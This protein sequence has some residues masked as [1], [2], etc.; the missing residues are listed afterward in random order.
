MRN[1]LGTACTDIEIILNQQVKCEGKSFHIPL[2]SLSDLLIAATRYKPAFYNLIIRPRV[3]DA[4]RLRERVSP[5]GKRRSLGQRRGID[6]PSRVE[7]S[8]RRWDADIHGEFHGVF[9][10]SKDV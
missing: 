5:V 8:G 6:G 2:G 7:K 4:L 10:E 9:Q 1:H 3:G